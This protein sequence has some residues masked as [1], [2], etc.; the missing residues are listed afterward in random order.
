VHP[1]L[2]A[3]AIQAHA[4]NAGFSLINWREECF[5]EEF[6]G[7]KEL[8]ASVKGIGAGN[9]RKDRNPGLLGK[10]KYRQFEQSMHKESTI[11][12]KLTLTYQVLFAEIVKQ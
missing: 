9:H 4:F 5:V 11:K 2:S 12:S 6:N 10:Q 3:E 8:L 1:F 7:L